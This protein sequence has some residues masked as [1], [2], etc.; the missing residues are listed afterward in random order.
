MRSKIGA[1]SEL[2]TVGAGSQA[3]GA[4]VENVSAGWS[5][6]AIKTEIV[7]RIRAARSFDR[8]RN[9]RHVDHL[10]CVKHNG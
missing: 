9:A 6:R 2:E 4:Q 7:I 5:E 8:A 10:S 1:R 3:G